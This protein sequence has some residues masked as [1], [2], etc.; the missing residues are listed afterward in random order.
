[1]V[2]SKFMWMGK[3]GRIHYI[4]SF[5][6]YDV[7]RKSLHLVLATTL[8][9][10]YCSQGNDLWVTGKIAYEVFRFCGDVSVMI[11]SQ[12][13]EVV[14]TGKT[15]NDIRVVGDVAKLLLGKI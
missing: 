9:K 3:D 8:F 11:P 12:L 4:N 10:T 5:K 15:G 14:L 6:A 13:L 2:E 1:M 7:A